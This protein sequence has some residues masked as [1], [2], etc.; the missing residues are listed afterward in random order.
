MNPRQ[1][2][3]VA[4]RRTRTKGCGF[5]TPQTSN[6]LFRIGVQPVKN[7]AVGSGEQSRDSHTCRCTCSQ[8]PVP[9]RLAPNAEQS[10]LCCAA[11]PWWL[12]ALNVAECTRPSQTTKRFE[13]VA[14]ATQ[15]LCCR[16]S[17]RPLQTR[18]GPL[19]DGHSGWPPSLPGPPHPSRSPR[20]PPQSHC[21][22]MP[23]RCF[24]VCFLIFFFFLNL[25]CKLK[26]LTLGQ[27]SL[28][29]MLC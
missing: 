26:K 13:P 21:M 17:V 27:P 15:H 11:G 4:A 16:C 1:R 28:R 5:S 9:P 19:C 24:L 29:R 22:S 8:T 18:P 2:K 7:V 25:K 12:P 20:A 10:P 23:C 6:F 14:L 3:V